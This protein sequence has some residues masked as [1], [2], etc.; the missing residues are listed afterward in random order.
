MPSVYPLNW[1][2]N[3]H[4]GDYP[5]FSKR[6]AAVWSRWL[7][8]YATRWGAFAYDVA[9][10]GMTLPDVG[11]SDAE[12]RGWQYM[13]ALK[14]DACGWTEE[15]IWIF[16]VRP[17]ARVSALGSALGYAL[18]CERDKVF[19]RKLIPAVVCESMQADVEWCCEQLGVRI[20]KV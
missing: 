12:R 11:A 9:V 6:D 19:D 8:E 20:F 1:V 10:G 2:A 16:E 13:T 4:R 7:A 14:I 5:H 3:T 15:A 17:E 18:V